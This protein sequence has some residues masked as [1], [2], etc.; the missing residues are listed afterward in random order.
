MGLRKLVSPPGGVPL[1]LEPIIAIIQLPKVL[2]DEGRVV[3]IIHVD[4]L[5]EI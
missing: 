5:D 3:N 4:V 1:L 2:M